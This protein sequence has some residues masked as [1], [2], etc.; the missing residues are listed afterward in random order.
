MRLFKE[1]QQIVREILVLNLM[2]TF[3]ELVV[4]GFVYA[5]YENEESVRQILHTCSTKTDRSLDD[6]RC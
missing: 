2:D 4:I 1:I 3:Y 5:I 6:G